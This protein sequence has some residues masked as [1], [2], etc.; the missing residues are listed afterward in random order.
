MVDNTIILQD[1]TYILQR[2]GIMLYIYTDGEH[3][4]V[5]NDKIHNDNDKPAVITTKGH[6]MIKN[7][8]KTENFIVIMMNLLLNVHMDIKNGIKMDSFIVI[9]INPQ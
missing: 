6:I 1:G 5:K 4:W 3:R 2:N 9:M 7:G 8:T